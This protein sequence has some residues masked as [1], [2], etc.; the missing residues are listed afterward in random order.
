MK[1]VLIKLDLS[2]SK[3]SLAAQLYLNS[4]VSPFVFSPHLINQLGIHLKAI[5][6]NICLEDK[7]VV[8]ISNHLAE[9]NEMIE[10]SFL[11]THS[12]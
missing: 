4:A 9:A 1:K 11:A 8:V 6:S 7:I 3:M 12:S 10:F 5:N 2:Q